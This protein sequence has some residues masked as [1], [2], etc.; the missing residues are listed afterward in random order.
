MIVDVVVD[1]KFTVMIYQY[2]EEF[3]DYLER[4]KYIYQLF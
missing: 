3:C 2:D 1:E 4:R